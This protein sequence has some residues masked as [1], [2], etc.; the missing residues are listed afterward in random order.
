[1]KPTDASTTDNMSG[2][3]VTA[4]TSWPALATGLVLMV[5]GTAYPRLLAD[6]VGHAD[7]VLA[8]LVFWAMT[9][10]FV[11]GVGFIPRHVTPRWAFSGWACAAALGA[12]ALF[13]AMG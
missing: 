10:G 5:V 8:L 3:F 7:H 11:R 2:S 1:M 13:R 9:A 12:A 6:A 4:R